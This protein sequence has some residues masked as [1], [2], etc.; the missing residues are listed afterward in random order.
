MQQPHVLRTDG[1]SQ[2]DERTDDGSEDDIIPPEHKLTR[3]VR[4]QRA[5]QTSKK[6][7][8][9]LMRF[10]STLTRAARKVTNEWKSSS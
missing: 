9:K 5:D 7:W 10:L 6:A 8:E 1:G 3:V 2:N 4:A